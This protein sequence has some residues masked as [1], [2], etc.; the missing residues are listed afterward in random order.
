MGI[1]SV[2]SC[3]ILI[4]L[5]SLCIFDQEFML[6]TLPSRCSFNSYVS[7][8]RS[9]ITSNSSTNS[10]HPLPR[11]V[12]NIVANTRFVLWHA[13]FPTSILTRKEIPNEPYVFD[14]QGMIH[15]KQIQKC[16]P[17]PPLKASKVRCKD[18]PG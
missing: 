2:T 15:V 18:C 13:K 7:K 6:H 11:R 5:I 14:V 16:L 10:F 12:P 3:T 8:F 1:S 17:S 4:T 9:I